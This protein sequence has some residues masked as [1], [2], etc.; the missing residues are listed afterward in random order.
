MS[1]LSDLSIL[2]P[3]AREEA[4]EERRRERR[5][6][7]SYFSSEL[8]SL[9]GA[10]SEEQT[11]NFLVQ[12]PPLAISHFAHIEATTK[13]L[14]EEEPLGLPDVDSVLDRKITRMEENI[15]RLLSPNKSE[16]SFLNF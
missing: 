14:E 4:R 12:L 5:E 1:D 2:Y 15:Q 11:M 3:Q 8:G 10:P 7:L 6:E 13:N 16:S 9:F